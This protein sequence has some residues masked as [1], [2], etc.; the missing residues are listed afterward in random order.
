MC[1]K[2]KSIAI[3]LSFLRHF[4]PRDKTWNVETFEVQRKIY[5]F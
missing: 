5:R 3:L 1:R 4:L 2:M